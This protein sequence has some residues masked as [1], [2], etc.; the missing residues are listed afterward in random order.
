MNKKFIPERLNLKEHRINHWAYPGPLLINIKTFSNND[1]ENINGPSL[2]KVPDWVENPLGKYY[3][4]FAHHRG[5]YIRMAY[6]DSIT[7]PY[8]LYEGGTL[9]LSQTIGNDHVASP[10]VHIDND[11]KE[12]IMYYH[13]PFEDWQYTFKAKSKDGLSFK[14]DKDKLGMF[15]FR[16]FEWRGRTFSVA[17]NRNTSG[18]S[19]E[20]IDGKWIPQDEN[21]IPMMRHAAVLVEDDVVY[22][23]YTIVGEAPESIY[24]SEV[25]IDNGWNLKNTYLLL[26]PEYH[27]EHA[28]LELRPSYFGGGVGNEL[29]DPCIYEENGKKY[30]LY[31]VIGECGIAIAEL[32][33][34]HQHMKKY[35]IWGMRRT[36]NHAITEWIASHFNKTIHNNDIIQ[37]KPW[38]TNLHGDGKIVDCYIDSY[39]DFEPGE[40]NENTIILLRDWYNLSASRLNSG[41]GWKNSCRYVNQH[42]YHRNCIEVYLKYC[43]LWEKYPDNFILYNK[44]VEDKNYVKEIEKRYGWYHVARH[45]KLPESGIGGGSSFKDTSIGSFT[46]RYLKIVEKYP[47]E[48]VEICSNKEINEYSKKIFGI[49]IEW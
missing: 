16:V 31:S 35:D 4:Y 23:F 45:D 36:G 17:K 18:I 38:V 24:C 14:S 30:I 19:Y 2:I 13:T 42:G 27:Y 5:E 44:W 21:F 1:G 39:E 47:E 43:E 41:R 9:K 25:D 34:Q 29:R 11:N 20:L 40:I 33:E 37:N 7:G 12:I 3:L 22:I 10:D 48:W 46:D 26:K 32:H 15:Y 8:T 6:S 49:E 28:N